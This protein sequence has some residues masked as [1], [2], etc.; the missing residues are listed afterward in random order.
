M[1]K[2]LREMY[3][4]KSEDEETAYSSMRVSIRVL[5]VCLLILRLIKRE[6]YK[7]ATEGGNDSLF[8]KR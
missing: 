3:V 8:K 6:A 2:N 5:F 4:R 1:N 7:M